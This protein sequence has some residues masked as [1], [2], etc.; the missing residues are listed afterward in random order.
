METME[1]QQL[2]T[3]SLTI[4]PFVVLEKDSAKLESLKEAQ[5]YALLR[6]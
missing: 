3:L 2:S 1:S 6:G 5:E 4:F